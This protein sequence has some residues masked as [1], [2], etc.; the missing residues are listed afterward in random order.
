MVFHVV[1]VTVM[2]RAGRRR[3]FGEMP[4]IFGGI[5]AEASRTSLP[6]HIG[7]AAT[8]PAADIV[9]RFFIQRERS[10]NGRGDRS[11]ISKPP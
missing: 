9:H 8:M 11:C 7:A 5:H 4:R 10:T 2:L 1:P 6:R 3:W